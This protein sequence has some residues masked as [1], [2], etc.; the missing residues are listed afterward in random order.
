V[1]EED[2]DPNFN[3]MRGD[4]GKKKGFEERRQM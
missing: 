3:A 2:P 4:K 1:S